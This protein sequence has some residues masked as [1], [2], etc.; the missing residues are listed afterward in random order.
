MV[1]KRFPRVGVRWTIGDVSNSG[2]EALQLS[3]WSVWNLLGP[4]AEYAV[5]V[6]SLPVCQAADRT[7]DIPP[8]VNWLQ[9]DVAVPSWLRP[10]VSPQMAEGVAWKFAPVR[11]FP[12][13]HELSLDNDVLLWA[14]PESIR[15][16]LRS[17]DPASCLMAADLQPALGKFSE[18]C[19]HRPLNSGIRGL[20]P[21]FDME[22]KLRGKLRATGITL[23]SELDEQGLQAAVLLDCP[24]FVVT[25]QEVSI[26]SPFPNHHQHLGTCGAH[27]VG[28]NVKSMPWTL[29]GRGAHE[30]IRENWIRYRPVIADFVPG[31]S[32]RNAK[33]PS[34]IAFAMAAYPAGDGCR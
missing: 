34:G 4:S 22:A 31:A 33:I 3:I 20:P 10:Y 24:L 15:S 25:T 32:H 1:E 21:N 29:D 2:F 8:Q 30:L 16:W 23:E 11:V 6:N 18:M 17:E 9:T 12:M 14:L 28:L 19:N 27:F 13:L 5:C 7:G 26:C